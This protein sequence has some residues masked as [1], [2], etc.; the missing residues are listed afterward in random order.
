VS[1]LHEQKSF[2]ETNAWQKANVNSLR[3]NTSQAGSALPIIFGTTRQS[4]NLIALGDYRGPNGGKK[5]K[6]SGPLPLSG[7]HVG[8]GGG[9]GKKGAGGKKSSDYSVDVDFALCQGPVTIYP[10]AKVWASAG[11]ARFDAVGLHFYPGDDGQT[12]DPVFAALGNIVGYSGTCHVTGTPMD[13]GKSPVLPNLSFEVTGFE[14]GSAGPNF[15]QDANPAYCIRSFLTDPR[16]GSGFPLAALDPDLVAN[17]GNYCQA[18]SFAI[19][20]SLQNQTDA[21]TWLSELARLT[22]TAI[23]W[24]GAVLKFIPYGDSAINTN[25]ALWEPD[26]TPRYSLTDDDFLP[27]DQHIDSTD[28]QDGADDPVLITRANPADATNWMSFEYLDRENDYNKT[29]IAQFDQGSID[30]YGLRTEASINGNCF[31]GVGPA[32]NALA[33]LLQRALYT[34]N[35][36]RFQLG[37]Q[38]ALLEPMDIVLLTDARCGLDEQAVRI[39]SIEENENG[40][41]TIEAEEI[42][43]ERAA[44][45]VRTGCANELIW[46]KPAGYLINLDCRTPSSLDALGNY[47]TSDPYSGGP[48][49]IAIYDRDGAETHVSQAQLWDKIHAFAGIDMDAILDSDNPAHAN[50]SSGYYGLWPILDGQ[51]V[52]AFNQRYYSGS[53]FAFWWALLEPGTL[54]CIGAHYY[55]GLTVWPYVHGQTALGALTADDPILVSA[56]GGIG[57]HNALLGVLPSVNQF[58]AG[59][60]ALVPNTILFP[61]GGSTGFSAYLW[62]GGIAGTGTNESND[63]GFLLPGADGNPILYIYASRKMIEHFRSG[64][65]ETPPEWASVIGPANPNGCIVKVPLGDLDY[66]TLSTTAFP[67][68][69]QKGRATGGYTVDNGAWQ[70]EGGGPA[71]PFMDEYTYLSDDTPGGTDCYSAKT[72]V[73]N[74]GGG[75][76]WIVFY[77]IGQSDAFR[78]GS[79]ADPYPHPIYERIKIFQ[80]NQATETARLFFNGTCI[81]HD[82]DDLPADEQTEF[83]EVSNDKQQVFSVEPVGSGVAL[84]MNSPLMR[85][86]FATLDIPVGA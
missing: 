63:W 12:V 50:R 14:A 22:N 42:K 2:L 80:Y 70:D 76:Y 33:L 16:W 6:S 81:L 53:A 29:L 35:T 8:K 17:Y 37:W 20:V 59:G 38:Y 71:I 11:T 30:R 74:R 45:A 55:T 48:D 13:L 10:Y 5:G 46:R 85:K 4:I 28:P 73:I 9:G 49:Y 64:S 21:A 51:Y 34:R 36:Y 24:S 1:L 56:Y 39:T 75:V 62:A 82:V 15:G 61:L 26:L 86:K 18:A 54:N 58:K 67:G 52:L 79:T 83:W 41:L 23:V 31:C 84:Y 40:D 32:Q 68:S 65:H 25:G 69:S 19:S 7:R 27:W 44:P 43:I 3:Y 60:A 47:Y 72:S 57:S 66:T 77:M 78:Y